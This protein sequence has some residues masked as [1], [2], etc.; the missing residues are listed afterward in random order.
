MGLDI[1]LYLKNN[2]GEER[3]VWEGGLTHNLNKMA[4]EANCYEPLWRPYMLHKNFDKDKIGDDHSLEDK[5]E[6]EHPMQ[7]KDIVHLLEKSLVILKND[8]ERFKKF[9]APNKWGTYND[10]IIFLKQ[11]TENCNW[12]PNAF[13]FAS[14]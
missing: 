9:D 4:M 11:Y 14:R 6:E 13:I 7:A 3:V 12:F 10:L 2:K 8:P 5:L 1:V